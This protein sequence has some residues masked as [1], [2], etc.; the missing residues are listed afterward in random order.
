MGEIFRFASMRSAGGSEAVSTEQK[1]TS[2]FGG[3]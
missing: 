1:R 3:F 2:D